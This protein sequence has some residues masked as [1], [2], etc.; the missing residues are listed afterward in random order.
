M[1]TPR[2]KGQPDVLACNGLDVQHE[3]GMSARMEH[4]TTTPPS[5]RGALG[6]VV[7]DAL[8]GRA[9]HGVPE[10]GGLERVRKASVLPQIPPGSYTALNCTTHPPGIPPHDHPPASACRGCRVFWPRW[11]K[12]P[13][14]PG[15]KHP[16]VEFRRTSKKTG[17]ACR[18]CFGGPL[19]CQG[20]PKQA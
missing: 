10:P 11:N 5:G 3:S 16:L 15:P 8:D 12:G 14:L 6:V 4:V 19:M 17:P 20:P 2:R 18:A 13:V 7:P 1:L 9:G